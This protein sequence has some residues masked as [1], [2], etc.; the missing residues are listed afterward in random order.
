MVDD[1]LLL[2]VVIRHAHMALLLDSFII[3][4]VIPAMA[5]AVG[6]E[7]PARDC[8]VLRWIWYLFCAQSVMTHGSIVARRGMAVSIEIH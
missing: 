5:P 7:G 4:G 2:Q 1:F 6:S 8:F 3:L